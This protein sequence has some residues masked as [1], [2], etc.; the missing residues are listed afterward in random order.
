MSSNFNLIVDNGCTSHMFPFKQ[1]FISYKE[2]PH[3]Y[4]I[5]ADKSKVACLGS[6][7]VSFSLQNKTIILFDALHFPKLSSPLLSA[8]CF[9]CLNGCNFIAHNNDSFL[10]FLM[11]VFPADDSPGCTISG[12]FVTLEGGKF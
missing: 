2:T 9:W 8:R 4:I 1:T 5:L 12:C 7:A 3:L 11:F 6:G 10:T